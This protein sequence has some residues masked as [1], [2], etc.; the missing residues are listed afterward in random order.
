MLGLMVW[1]SLVAA[2]PLLALSLALEGPAAIREGLTHATW[3]TWAAV[4]YIAY[5]TTLLAFALWNRLLSRHPA[6]TVM[7]FALLVPVA[8]IGSTSLLLAEPFGP[9]AAAGA[10]L[11]LAGL[12][13]NVW[14][15]SRR[16]RPALRV[17]VEP[18]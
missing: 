7:P 15:V 2:A 12:A 13:L 14:S 10:A 6:A 16:G 8:G 4:A 9:V 17:A 11:V 3:H 1:S 18:R 5:P